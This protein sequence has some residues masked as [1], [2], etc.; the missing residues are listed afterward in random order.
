M[1]QVGRNLGIA[2]YYNLEATERSLN[3]HGGRQ[4]TLTGEVALLN[5]RNPH[6]AFMR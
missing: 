3:L 2:N 4:L 1:W 6:L 5:Q